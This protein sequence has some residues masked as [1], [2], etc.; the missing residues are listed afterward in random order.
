VYEDLGMTSRANDYS[1]TSRE[2]LAKA[3]EALTQ[4]DLLQASEKG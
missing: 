2:L 1:L 3:Q 4:D